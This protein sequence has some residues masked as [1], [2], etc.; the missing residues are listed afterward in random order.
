MK[1][2]FGIGKLIED[3]LGI[4]K[5][6]TTVRLQIICNPYK[7]TWVEMMNDNVFKPNIFVELMKREDTES[8]M[9]CSIDYE[10]ERKTVLMFAWC[11]IRTLEAFLGAFFRHHEVLERN[12]RLGRERRDNW[13]EISRKLALCGQPSLL[14]IGGGQFNC[15]ALRRDWGPIEMGFG[16]RADVWV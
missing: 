10:I 6:P 9:S 12:G 7:S 16:W 4:C 1:S 2:T 3:S 8:K 13:N 15:L 5:V 14:E 11:I